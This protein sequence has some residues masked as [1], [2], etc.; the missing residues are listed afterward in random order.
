MSDDFMNVGGRSAQFPAVGTSV[1][2]VVLSEPDKQ[3]DK[4]MDGQPR[5]FPSGDPMWVYLVQLQTDLRDPNDDT[6]D[7]V[8]TLW[9]K[10]LSQKAVVDA[11][12]KA[13]APGLRVGGVLTVTYT[14]DIPPAKRGQQPSKA[15]AAI[16]IPPDDDTGFMTAPAEVPAPVAAVRAEDSMLA[17]LR[18]QAQA[19]TARVAAMSR[20]VQD[21][22]PPF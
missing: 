1:T 7:G 20:G 13:R 21:V 3:P 16:Y 12:R 11:V 17:R 10:Y 4:D 22:E 2:G 9:L 15:Y 18:A 14:H 5:T 19:G 6:D 8:R